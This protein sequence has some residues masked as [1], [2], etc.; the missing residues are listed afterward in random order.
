[1]LLVDD[2]P[3]LTNRLRLRDG[4]GWLNGLRLSNVLGLS[5][6]RLALRAPNIEDVSK[7]AVPDFRQPVS[8]TLCGPGYVQSQCPVTGASNVLSKLD[9]VG[10]ENLDAF[11]STRDGHVPLLF[12]GRRCDGGIGE[13]DII[14]GLS[15]GSVGS[16][17]VAAH[18]LSVVLVQHPPILQRNAPV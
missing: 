12:V 11:A 15:L 3:G 6:R 16:D 7:V 9:F 10:R 2:G 5:L 18:E 13:Q 8:E 14:H 4:F 1:M 17:G